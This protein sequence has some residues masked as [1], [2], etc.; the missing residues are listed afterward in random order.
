[1][2]WSYP[3]QWAQW[4]DATPGVA[5]PPEVT[6]M[7]FGD[8]SFATSNHAVARAGASAIACTT[9]E[10]WFEPARDLTS[11]TPHGSGD[12][13]V[14]G[15]RRE[16]GR[17]ITIGGFVRGTTPGAV[18]DAKDALLRAAGTFVV[19]ELDRG[20]ARECTARRTALTWQRVAPTLERFTLTLVADDP[21]RYASGSR[22]LTNGAQQLFNRGDRTAW[23]VLEVPGLH[24]SIDIIHPTGTWTLLDTPAG[25]TRLVDLRNGDVWQNGVRAFQA[26]LG[27]AP[28]VLPGGS[29]WIVSGVDGRAI[30]RRF[31]AWS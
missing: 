7:S 6:R 10:G 19:E 9:L 12:G 22:V 27:P 2:N 5:V 13:L 8:L 25:V 30:V 1:M 15:A 4:G 16:S 3:T 14:S 26:D 18:G 28:I 23:P 24:G 17:I 29:Q 21:L 11:S 20:L 31:E